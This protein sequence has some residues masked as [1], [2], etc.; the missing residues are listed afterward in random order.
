MEDYRKLLIKRIRLLSAL[1]L[2]TV[3][4]LIFNIFFVPETERIPEVY[5]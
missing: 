1:V 3:S 4:I 5:G 2:F